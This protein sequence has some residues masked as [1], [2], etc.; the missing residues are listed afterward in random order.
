LKPF[1]PSAKPTKA[2]QTKYPASEKA[3]KLT[4]EELL[5]EEAFFALGKVVDGK[6]KSTAT[7]VQR[8]KCRLIDGL[9]LKELAFDPTVI[10][11][12]GGSVPDLDGPPTEVLDISAIRIGKSLFAAPLITRMALRVDLTGLRPSDIVRIFIVALKIDGC[13]QVMQH[14]LTPMLEKPALRALLV[15]D[16]KDITLSSALKGLRIRHPS[17]HPIE[18]VAVPL[19]K[20]GGSGV[21]VYSAGVVVDEYPRMAGDEA[22]A[23]KSVEQFRNAVA[24]RILPGGLQLYTGSPWH[25]YGPAYDNVQTL[26]GKHEKSKERNILVLRTSAKPF[27]N[28]APQWTTESVEKLQ[29]TNPLAYKT[30]FLA[31][32]ADGEEAVFPAQSIGEAWSRP[33]P[34]QALYGRPAVFADP[35]ALRHDYWAAIVAGWAYP[36]LGP[37]DL[38]ECEILGDTITPSPTDRTGAI[39]SGSKGWIRVLEDRYGNPIPKLNTESKPYFVV[40]DVVS[41]NKASGARGGD[42]VRA[43]GQLARTYGCD[44]FH[45]DGYEQLMLSDAVRSQGL[46]PVVH[47]WSGQ[48]RKTEAVDH[49]RTLLIERR[50]ELPKPPATLGPGQE[51]DPHGLLKAELLGFRRRT[52]P[53]GNFQY[54]VAGGAG[55]GDH[56]SCLTLAMRADLDGFVDRSPTKSAAQKHVVHDHE[57]PPDSGY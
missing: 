25:P 6:Y 4:L 56:A 53:C 30:D 2:T 20:G 35:S 36:H 22:G 18:V 33:R 38:Y 37:E 11:L 17:G 31:E 39:V 49:L 5:T 43:V 54:V 12:C 3:A 50:V 15:D 16:P 52:S 32:F 7:N 26:F 48:G 42:L 28:I 21:S 55:H 44:E 41:W 47:T 9:P 45:W 57:E 8:A 29:R 24:G 1:S 27:V 10:E 46:R 23:V 40:Y 51:T 34:A 14:L 19:D 13:K